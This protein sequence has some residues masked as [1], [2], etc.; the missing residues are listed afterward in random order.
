MAGQ[1]AQL[2][3]AHW[4]TLTTKGNLATMLQ[5]TG[6]RAEAWRLYEEVLVR[7]TAQLGPAHP[8]NLATKDNLRPC[9]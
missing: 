8:V 7:Q 9:S 4:D 6:G 5:K 2:G 3:P 1:T